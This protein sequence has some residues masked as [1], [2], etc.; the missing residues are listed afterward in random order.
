MIKFWDQKY[1]LIYICLYIH[2]KFT[3]TARI[4]KE[5]TFKRR[6]LKPMFIESQYSTI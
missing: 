4:C 3:G 1:F 5:K 6:H 2:S